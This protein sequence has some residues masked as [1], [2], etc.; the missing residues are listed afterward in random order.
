MFFGMSCVLP[1]IA[2]NSVGV[3]GGIHIPTAEM[4]PGGTL[5]AGG[6]FV[7][8]EIMP[9]S[10]RYA[11]T[12]HYYVNFTMFPAL[13][14]GL[15]FTLLKLNGARHYN[16]QDRNG[17]V[18]LRLWKQGRLGLPQVVIGANSLFSDNGSSRWEAYYIVASRRFSIGGDSR[19]TVSAGYY[20]PL[21]EYRKFYNRPFGGINWQPQIFPLIFNKIMT[22]NILAEYDSHLINYGVQATM[23]RHVLCTMA[24][25]D[26]RRWTW[27]LSFRKQFSLFE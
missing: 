21:G 16:N 8:K 5:M 15:N 7:P 19:L 13:E 25:T 22:I 18:R 23:F 10:S 24:W 9:S 12:Y 27:S 4:Q 11:D 6:G 2:Q 1:L 17:T 20:I 3:T 26:C 14:A